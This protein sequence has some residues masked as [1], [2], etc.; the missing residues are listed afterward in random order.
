MAQQFGENKAKKQ[1]MQLDLYQFGGFV[2]MLGEEER[3]EEEGS[4]SKSSIPKRIAV[5]L[6]GGAVN[7][8]FGLLVYF[9]LVSTSGNYI[10]TTIDTV[11]P[12]HAAE[13]AG[14]EAGDKILKIDGKTVRLRSDIENA[15]KKSEGKEIVVTVKR[16]N[17]IKDIRLIPNV[18]EKKTIGIYL[19][20]EQDI[21]SSKIKG[22]YENS[23]AE[24]AGLQSGDLI[25]EINGEQ[26]LNDPYKVVNLINE[27]KTEEI[28]VKI[29]RDNEIKTFNVKIR[30]NQ[31]YKLGVTF[32][33]AEKTFINNVYYGF[34]DTLDFSV[35]IIDNIKML[36]TGNVS[37]DQLTGPI[38]ISEA[39]SKTQGLVEF[40]YMLALISL[41][42]RSN[43]PSSISTT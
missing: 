28:E 2:N 31:T 23:P 6:A 21:L 13:T 17:E 3:S 38:G 39:V 9:I 15:L 4:F 18:E 35:S 8:I 34:W 42:L 40:V 12:E 7:I 19:G 32:K 16:E 36:F 25:I 11:I 41:S 26:T 43:K 24:N 22:I 5:V 27:S 20:A 30:T 33:I 10:S 29:N 1:N 14:I 37:V